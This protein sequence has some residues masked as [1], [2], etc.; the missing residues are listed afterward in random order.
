MKR[1]TKL[2]AIVL[3]AALLCGCEKIPDWSDNSES[4]DSHSNSSDKSG[5]FAEQ[6]TDTYSPDEYKVLKQSYVKKFEAEKGAFNGKAMDEN[7]ELENSDKD[8][9][10]SLNEGQY[11]KQVATVVSSQFYRVVISARSDSG[12]VIKL[13]IGDTT[14]GAYSVTSTEEEESGGEFKLFALDNLYMSVGMNTLNFSVESGSAEID[15]IVVEDSEAVGA[16]VYKTGSA[17]VAENV[18]NRTITLLQTLSENYGKVSFLAQ[19]VSCGTNA[20]INALFG[21]FRRYPAIR[22]SELAQVMKDDE[23]SA[24]VI[25]SDISLAKDWDANGG[26]CAYKWH[27]YSPNSARAIDTEAFDLKTA[28]GRIDSKEFAMLD[29]DAIKLQLENGLMTQDAAQLLYDIDRLAETLKILDDADIP[30]LFEPIPDGDAGLFWWGNDS[31][32]YKTLWKIIFL[33]LTQYNSLKNLVWVW[34]NGNFD[35]YPGDKYVDIIGQSFYE[36]SDSSFADCFGTLAGNSASGRKMLAVTA[37]D[38]LP[39]INY[40]SRDNAMWLWIAPDSG[41]YLIDM[42]GSI[43]YN[44]NKKTALR[45]AYDNEKCVT[46]DELAALGYE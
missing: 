7:G 24:E 43:S 39:N 27:W 11:L 34:D 25:D 42:S 8:G 2:T 31:G 18:S 23:H 41:E 40:M 26:I 22:V 4:S 46:R 35:Y 14:V 16:E 6:I 3:A 19:N 20:E 10:V 1:Y 29:D 15:C 30:V 17:P 21:E 44:Y 9:F 32:S 45:Y 38:T 33:R 5:G 12:A 36:K 28:L 13:K 37:C